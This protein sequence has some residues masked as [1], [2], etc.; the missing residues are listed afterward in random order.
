MGQTVALCV[1]SPAAAVAGGG[2]NAGDNQYL[3]PFSG[4]V[5]KHDTRSG[6]KTPTPTAQATAPASSAGSAQ[7]TAAP[8][9]NASARTL[10]RTGFPALGLLVAGLGCLGAGVT[11]R[12]LA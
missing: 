12:R 9:A 6:A 8:T 4:T 7:G 5:Q 3:D 10:P 2:G 1:A 11:L